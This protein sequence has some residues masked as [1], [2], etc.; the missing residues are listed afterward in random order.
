MSIEDHTGRQ[1]A[2]SVDAS[3]ED[4]GSTL[5]AKNTQ[6]LKA[7]IFGPETPQTIEVPDTPPVTTGER[8][9]TSPLHKFSLRGL[10]NRLVEEAVAKLPLLGDVCMTGDVTL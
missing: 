3:A 6:Q 7:S 10:G 9:Y 1:S 8:P 2:S 5:I 4:I